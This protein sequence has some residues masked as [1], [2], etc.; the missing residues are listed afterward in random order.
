MRKQ[1]N[2]LLHCF[3]G[4]DSNQFSTAVFQI[5]SLLPLAQRSQSGKEQFQLSGRFTLFG[6]T[7]PHQMIVEA[8]TQQGWQ[9]L[10]GVFSIKHSDFGRKPFSKALGAISIA[11][12]VKIWGDAW[13]APGAASAVAGR[14]R[15]AVRR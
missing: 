14:S 7:R 4:L 5:D 6:V 2:E 12:E 11:D 9:H 13:I 1:I 15:A 3:K 8:E 10:V